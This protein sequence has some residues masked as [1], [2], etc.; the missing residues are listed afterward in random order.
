MAS[1]WT[2]KRRVRQTELIR[3]WRPWAKSTGPRTNEG[4]A[5]ASRN[6]YKG[7]HWLMLRELSRMVNAEVK[8]GQDL[9]NAIHR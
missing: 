9:V 5:K 4:K 1:S 7:G 3:Q 2:P 8:A 6:A